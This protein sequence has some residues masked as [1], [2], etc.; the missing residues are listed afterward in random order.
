M[1]AM[2]LMGLRNVL[3]MGVALLVLGSSSQAAVC[4]LACGLPTAVCHRADQVIVSVESHDGMAMGGDC[5][6]DEM[7]DAAVPVGTDGA[8]SCT[9]Q[10]CGH[11]APT[12]FEKTGIAPS[13]APVM[14]WVTASGVPFHVVTVHGRTRPP[15]LVSSAGPPATS[16]RI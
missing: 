2:T 14:Q 5:N 16:L 9:Q 1:K 13:F 7:K 4:E 3:A 6:H 12:V 11:V 8:A 10:S 15:L